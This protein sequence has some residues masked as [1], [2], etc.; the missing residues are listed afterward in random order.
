[1]INETALK[2]AFQIDYGVDISPRIFYSHGMVELFGNYTSKNNGKAIVAAANLG[3]M[4]Y[5]APFED[6]VKIHRVGCEEIE[7]KI[8]DIE[9]KEEEKGTQISLIKGI[10]QAAKA[11][12]YE[13]GGFVLEIDDDIHAASGTCFLAAFELLIVKILSA[14]YNED[15]IV[16]YEMALIA[17]DG[18]TR[19]F[20]PGN[21]SLT[22]MAC[23]HGGFNLIDFENPERPVVK[24]L[25]WNNALKLVLVDAGNNN[26]KVGSLVDKVNEDL[27]TVSENV[28]GKKTLREVERKDVNVIL[29]R[30]VP[31]ISED[32]KLRAQHYFGELDRIEMAERALVRGDDNDLLTNF[33]LSGL[34]MRSYLKVGMV[35]ENY[36]GSPAEAMDKA[37]MCIG[38]GA[39]K[40]HRDG[41]TGSIICLVYPKDYSNFRLTM[42]ER[43]GDKAIVVLKVPTWGPVELKEN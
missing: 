7:I 42:S 10:L 19:Y 29:S 31:G 25:E 28:F 3:V 18:E 35:G 41:F 24:P 21:S 33:K 23:A 34:S 43:F 1:M 32:M 4:G 40:I 37:A 36:F 15:A 5:A 11:K 12:G 9:V 26:F 2:Q 20:R 39:F 22:H 38:N 8:S 16:N 13:I 27:K 30:Y 6:I 14:F 17:H